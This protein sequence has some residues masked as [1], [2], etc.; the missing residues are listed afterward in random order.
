M[1]CS[2]CGAENKVGNKFCGKCGKELPPD[3]SAPIDIIPE[4][5]K[6]TVQ[7]IKKYIGAVLALIVSFSPF[8]KM[9][10]IP[11]IEMVA[12][13]LGVRISTDFS[14]IDVAEFLSDVK[15]ICN[16]LHIKISESDETFIK[17]FMAV[18][19]GLYV[20]CFIT[21]AA[22]IIRLIKSGSIKSRRKS[23]KGIRLICFLIFID[24]WL[25]LNAVDS[26]REYAEDFYYISG[27]RL[28]VPAS[29]KE[30]FLI[31]QALAFVLFFVSIFTTSILKKQEKEQN[32][33]VEN[34]TQVK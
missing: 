16:D 10:Y 15:D 2:F 7:N 21:A 27:I 14:F 22:N 18:C 26:I 33:E 30:G 20:V 12:S 3:N 28:N 9:Y 8:L 32:K 34:N 29:C 4:E 5:Y 6:G 24:N 23:W 11:E 17:V 25:I 31:I 19:A 1:K 13:F